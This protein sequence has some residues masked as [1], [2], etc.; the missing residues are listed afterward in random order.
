M[1]SIRENNSELVAKIFRKSRNRWGRSS[2]AEHLHCTR[3]KKEGTKEE[4]KEA[5]KKKIRSLYKCKINTTTNEGQRG[6]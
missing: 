1:E 5:E 4:M 2:V 6:V 3:K